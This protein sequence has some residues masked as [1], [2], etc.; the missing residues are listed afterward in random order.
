MI[1]LNDQDSDLPSS[2][3]QPPAAPPPTTQAP[4]APPQSDSFEEFLFAHMENMEAYM[5]E[6]FNK[7]HTIQESLE[8]EVKELWDEIHILKTKA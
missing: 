7:L 8:S 4:I 3:A 6:N 5:V 1:L 2:S